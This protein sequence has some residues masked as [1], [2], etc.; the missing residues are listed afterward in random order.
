MANILGGWWPDSL[1]AWVGCARSRKRV[2]HEVWERCPLQEGQIEHKTCPEFSAL[3]EKA[4]KV[5]Q[6]SLVFCL[7]GVKIVWWW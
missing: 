7:R 3:P 1:W 4:Q 2:G 5:Y 6:I